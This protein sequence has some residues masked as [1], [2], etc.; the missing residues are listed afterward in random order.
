MSLEQ[1]R[2]FMAASQEIRFEGR[3]R[4]EI[5]DWVRQTAIEQQ[6]HVQGKA[7]KGLLRMLHRQDDRL[8]PCAGD[9]ADRAV[10]GDGEGGG[11]R[12]PAGDAFRACTRG[13]TSSCWP[14]WMKPMRRSADQ[15]RRRSCTGSFTS[16]ENREYE[17]LA[18]LSVAHLY[19]LR[20]TGTY[21]KRR[22][23]YQGTRPTAVSI[24]E[25]AEAGPAR[26][27]RIPARRHGPPGRPGRR[28][29]VCITSMRWMR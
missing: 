8:E 5:Y 2:A 13:G 25:T 23:V 3:N 4:K 1:I 27:A 15:R 20:K 10:S 29:K 16:L 7:G 24:G 11:K 28:A 12:I 21:R 22:V 26:P 19:N 18:R 6:Y 9:P 14:K 17:R